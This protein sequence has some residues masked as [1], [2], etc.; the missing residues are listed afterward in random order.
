MIETIK[1]LMIDDHP[2]II[3]GYQNTLQFTKKENQILNIDIA[4]NCDQAIDCM[5]KSVKSNNHYNVLFVDIS[6]PPSKDGIMNSGEDLAIYA[7]KM[8]PKAKIIILTMFDESYRIHNIIKTIK[9]EGFLIKSDLTSSELSSAFQAVLY[10]P[11]FYS[12]TVNSHLRKINESDIV[13]DDKNRKILYLLSQ[14]AKNKS[15]AA[16]LDI[17]L[18]AIEKRKKQLKEIFLI[19]DGQD[20]T[21]INEARKRGFIL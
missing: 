19:D 11:P 2:M 6:L 21:L 17:S 9:P 4:N 5:Y 18:S 7:R 1:I 20:E 10:N 12:G 15:L 16:H 14:G 13:I 3:E 8:L